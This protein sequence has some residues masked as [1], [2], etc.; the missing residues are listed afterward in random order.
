MLSSTGFL[1]KL[2]HN[3]LINVA[4]LFLSNYITLKYTFKP[5]PKLL[6][7]TEGV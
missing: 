5:H 3:A 6:P 1:V 7:V 2:R 4:C